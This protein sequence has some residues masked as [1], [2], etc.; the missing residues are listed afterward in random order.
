MQGSG[1]GRLP[2]KTVHDGRGKKEGKLEHELIGSEQQGS[3]AT[4]FLCISRFIHTRI[5]AADPAMNS[6]I[7]SLIIVVTIL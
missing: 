2:K 5:Q 7:N 6:T 1:G 4:L 3:E